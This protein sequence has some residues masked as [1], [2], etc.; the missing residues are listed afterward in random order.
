M[1]A[2]NIY[3][4]CGTTTRATSA[5]FL[6]LILSVRTHTYVTRRESCDNRKCSR[7]GSRGPKCIC[8]IFVKKNVPTEVK[9]HC[10][11]QNWGGNFNRLVEIPTV[12]LLRL[13]FRRH[14]LH[15]RISGR[16]YMR[17][18]RSDQTLLLSDRFGRD[19]VYSTGLVGGKQENSVP[20]SCDT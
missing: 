10:A 20:G 7:T 3:Y 19:K 1:S 9:G 17:N 18:E 15:S 4:I 11:T 2:G 16:I 12:W 6:L 5:V 14:R 13:D 8:A